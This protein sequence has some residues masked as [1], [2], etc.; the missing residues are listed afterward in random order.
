MTG[1]EDNSLYNF[2][3][4]ILHLNEGKINSAV[5]LLKKTEPELIDNKD[6]NELFIN[7][8]K[9]ITNYY[10]GAVFINAIANGNL[11]VD[12]PEDPQRQNYV[13]AQYKQLH[14]NL[15]HLTWQTQQIAKGDL[16]QKVS[17]LG[18]FSVAFNKMIEA[19]REKKQMEDKIKL[20]FEELQKLNAEKDKFFSIIAHDLR[21]PLGAFMGLTEM[22][23]DDSQCFTSEQHK[24][25]TLDLSHSA[26]NIYNLLENLLE[27][28][29]MQRGLTVFKPQMLNLKD[30]VNDCTKIVIES[31]RNKT[32]EISINISDKQEVFADTNM[33]QTV[34]RNLVSNA[35]KFTSNGGK[36]TI[37]AG[38]GENN[39]ITIAV[40]D[41]GIGMTTEMQENLFRIDSK[42]NRPGTEGEPSTGLG[43]LLCK[44]FIENHNGK[45]WVES[46]QGKGSTFYFSVP[47][48]SEKVDNPSI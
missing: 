9:F 19:L 10:N 35:I 23:V 14:S 15:R 4:I 46:E 22:M 18:E 30:L 43:L 27:W 32:V 26:R 17:F 16:K 41:N 8:K 29:K 2:N 24:E 48:N 38:P 33:V 44:E 31:A 5:E 25:L 42:N 47:S 39:M 3:Q 37:S 6:C 1:S 28:S 13:I 21:G 36:V 7:F 40:K 11:N 45:I 34:I 12:P 20:Q